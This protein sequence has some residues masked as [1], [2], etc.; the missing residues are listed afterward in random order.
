MRITYF[1]PRL[2]EG[3][4]PIWKYPLGGNTDFN[5]RLREGGD[6]ELDAEDDINNISIHASAKEA[7][8]NLAGKY[9][10]Y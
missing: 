7:T 10:G 6:M 9:A 5:P 4:D 8:A 2:R 3:G 1:N